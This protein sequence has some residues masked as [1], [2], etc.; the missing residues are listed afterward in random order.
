VA[1]EAPVPVDL[2]QSTLEIVLPLV[3]RRASF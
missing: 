2:C 1:A 3:A